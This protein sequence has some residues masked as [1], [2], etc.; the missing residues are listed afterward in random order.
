MFNDSANFFNL[1]TNS[2][3]TSLGFFNNSVLSNTS[4]KL[5]KNG[6]QIAVNTNTNTSTPANG[7]VFISAVND[8]SLSLAIAFD[9]SQKSFA[10]IGNGLSDTEASNL[11]TRVQ[12][13]QTALSRQV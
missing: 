7:N 6:T 5:Y 3:A 12:A 2:S 13:F 9:T 11:Y 10:S 4:Q 1:T 8:A